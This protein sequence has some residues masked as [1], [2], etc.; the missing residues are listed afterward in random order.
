MVR[1]V[2]LIT[3]HAL[4]T[5]MGHQKSQNSESKHCENKPWRFEE[6]FYVDFY[7]MSSDQ[8][9]IIF[10]E[11]NESAENVAENTLDDNAE[12]LDITHVDE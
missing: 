7:H 6:P 5:N 9:I 2:T 12:I 4:L 1:K 11:D 10:A 3:T 8:R